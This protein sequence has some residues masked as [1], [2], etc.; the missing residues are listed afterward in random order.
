MKDPAIYHITRCDN[1]VGIRR[2][3]GL[4]SDAKMSAKGLVTTSI[5]YSH[6]KARRLRHPVTVAAGG[7]LGDYVPFNF[8]PRSVM[9]FVVSRGHP[10][11]SGGQESVVHLVSSMSA[12]QATGRRWFFTDQHA[13]L[14]YS[15]QYEDPAHLDQVD[16]AVMA[17]RQWG[18][19]A[20]VK[21]KR[22]AEFL[23]HE[24]C[25]WEVI[26]AIGVIDEGMAKVVS[27]AM[28]GAA[29]QPRIV[30]KRDWYY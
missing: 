19:N 23:V 4:W 27:K 30:V 29:H 14:G 18:G 6:I 25:P 12:V 9:L 22:Q 7:T 17:R 21:E 5:G 16:W 24:F 2:E 15:Q 1:L 26:Q 3:G 11:Y 8:C 28:V 10:D 13:D 20:D